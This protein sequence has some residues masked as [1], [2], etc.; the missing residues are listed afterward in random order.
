MIISASYRT[1]IPAFYGRW[2]VGRLA[3][4]RVR[5]TNPYG[6]PP[7]RVSLAPQ[8]V[9]G[10]V[11]WTRNLEPFAAGLAAVE[12][13]G[14]PY[15]VQF[16]ATGYPRALERSTIGAER[17]VAQMRALRAR[18]GARALV[19]RYDPI[20]VSSLTPPGW[21]EANF[22]GLAR[23]LEGACDE[24]VVSVAQPYRKTARTLDAAA[25]AHG[26]SWHDP[27]AEEKRALIG[28][29]AD[30]AGGH[31]MALTLCSQPG[32]VGIAGTRPAVCVDAVRLSDLAGRPLAA[33]R[34]GNR[35]GCACFESRDIGAYDSCPQGCAYC[36][37]VS[38]HA[39]ARGRLLAHDPD[40]EALDG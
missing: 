38:S 18:R 28:R 39:A 15:M 34:K 14:L 27:P 40:G 6:G 35:E 22:A 30:I 31:G 19:W 23:S 26:F 36:Y 29:L 5:V 37:A 1:D 8:D 32:L 11:F 21:H 3:A 17:A 9:D 24:V 33:R 7:G 12:A 4:G 25:R 2:F 16:T 13:L 10:F 20:L